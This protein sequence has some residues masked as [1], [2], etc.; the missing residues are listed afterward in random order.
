[1]SDEG[2]PGADKV[3]DSLVETGD[4]IPLTHELLVHKTA[5]DASREMLLDHL[6]NP[7]GIKI[8][9]AREILNTTRKYIVPLFELLDRQGFTVR[10]GDVRILS[11]SW[12]PPSQNRNT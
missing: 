11:P 7:E 10:R 1:M 6:R 5:L 3:M 12:T 4:L 2:L 8:S 9:Q